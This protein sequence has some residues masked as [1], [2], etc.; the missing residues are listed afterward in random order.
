M[1]SICQSVYAS[2]L[3]GLVLGFVASPGWGASNFI[4][5]Q[6]GKGTSIE[7][8]KNW[9]VL[10][11][12]RRV[13][14]ETFVESKGFLAPDAALNFAANHYDDKGKLLALVQV[15]F[16]PENPGTQSV[17]R[18]ITSND[19]KE[20]DAE[21]RKSAEATTKAMGARLTNWYGS[22]MKIING[23]YVMVHEH[24]RSGP[25]DAGLMAI[26][27]LRVWNSPR[28]L[29]VTFNYRERDAVMLRPIIDYMAASLWQ[30]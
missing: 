10:S 16:Y 2:L 23:L 6:L 17:A 5:V 29:S 20:I 1:R 28:S 22:K 14:I 7:V 24:Q 12:N 19:L 18:N 25:G 4:R 3:L 13:T 15:W 30:R 27:G 11:D 9:I 26:R 21:I 8:P